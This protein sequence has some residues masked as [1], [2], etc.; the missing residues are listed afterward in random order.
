MK[1][2]SR[3]LMLGVG[4][5]IFD[6]APMIAMHLNIYACLSAF[7]HWLVLAFMIPAVRWSVKSW[8]KGIV[9]ALLLALPVMILVAETDIVSIAPMI[10]SSLI[11]GA[12]IGVLG[13]K[14]VVSK[15]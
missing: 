10:I 2:F 7:V 13:E 11:L 6:V 1:K 9:L 5:G 15:N 8:L 12:V 4:A 3:L 14:I